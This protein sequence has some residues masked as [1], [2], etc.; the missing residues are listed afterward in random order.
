M[1]RTKLKMS[2]VLVH[3]IRVLRLKRTVSGRAVA[4][5]LV[6]VVVWWTLE[7][8]AEKLVVVVVVMVSRPW[9]GDADKSRGSLWI[10]AE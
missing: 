5:A 9:L 10:M 4:A 2:P 6:V 8:E 1:K 3:S 7:M